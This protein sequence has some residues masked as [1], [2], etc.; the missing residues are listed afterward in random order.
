MIEKI[1]YFTSIP[2]TVRKS[3]GKNVKVLFQTAGGGDKPFFYSTTWERKKKKSSCKKWVKP[4]LGNVKKKERKKKDWINLISKQLSTHKIH[5]PD[6]TIQWIFPFLYLSLLLIQTLIFL[7]QNWL[8]SWNWM[9]K[10]PFSSSPP[11][12]W[13]H[14]FCNVLFCS[15][16]QFRLQFS[17]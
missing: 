1:I 15:F 16:H 9:S 3:R 10:T 12:L 11:L 6:S 14:T 5:F 4:Q 13:L 7:E 2:R 17:L 8:F